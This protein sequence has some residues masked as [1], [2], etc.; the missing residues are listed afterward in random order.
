MDKLQTIPLYEIDFNQNNKFL[1]KLMMMRAEEGGV[2][3]KEQYGNRK[4]MRAIECALN[5]RLIFDI[6]R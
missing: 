6:L 2:L 1:G 5:K 3:A 4:Q